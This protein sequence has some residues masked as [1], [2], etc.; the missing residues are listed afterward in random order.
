MI[1]S[2]LAPALTSLSPVDLPPLASLFSIHP[3]HVL[4]EFTPLLIPILVPAVFFLLLNCMV[5]IGLIAKTE[6]EKARQATIRLAIEKG[7]PLPPELVKEGVPPKKTDDR[8]SGLIL[9]AV[10]V[11][12]FVALRV[13][14][15]F[16]IHNVEW[17]AAIPFLIGVALLVNCALQKKKE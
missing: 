2:S 5:G 8:K 1:L 15:F 12:S 9:I 16:D 6:Q 4:A 17:F 13:A 11:G 3:A 14:D 10:G 7:Q